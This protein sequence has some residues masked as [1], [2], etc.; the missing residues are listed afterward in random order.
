MVRG[1]AIRDILRE[2]GG[3]RFLERRKIPAEGE[4]ES[5]RG[6]SKKGRV[7]FLGVGVSS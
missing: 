6:V 7:S 3:E 1:A 5:S 2:R 4:A